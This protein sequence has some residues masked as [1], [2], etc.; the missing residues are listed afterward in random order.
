MIKAL[1]KK[2]KGFTLIETVVSVAIFALISF[3]LLNLFNAVFRNIKN[4]KA[5]LVANTIAVER[6][7][8]IRGM[9]FNQVKTTTGWVGGQIPSETNIVRDGINFLVRTDITWVDDPYDGV[10][11]GTVNDSFPFDYKKVRVRI[12]WTNPIGGGSQE[13]AT[14]TDVAPM[15]LEGLS[16]GKGGIYVT[17]YNSEGIVVSEADVEVNSN[18]ESYS[19]SGVKTDLNG[20]LWIPDLSPSDDYHIKVTKSG[21][22]VAETYAVNNDPSSE[23]YNP[24]PNPANALVIEQKITKIGFQIDATGMINI[25]TVHFDNPANW[26]VNVSGAGEQTESAMAISAS[27]DVFVAWADDRDAEKHIYMQK[28][29]YNSGTGSYDASWSSDARVVN[30]PDSSYPK[31]KIVPDGSLYLAW[32]DNR[33]SNSNIY[34]QEINTANGNLIGSEYQIGHDSS[35]SAQQN[36]D[37]TND[38]DGNLYIVWEDYRNATW[39]IYMQKFIPSSGTFWTDDLKINNSG[40]NEQINAKVVSDRNTDISGGNQNNIYVAWQSNHSGNFDILFSKFNKDGAV[41]FS[42]YV[43]NSD[44]GSLNQYNPS[45]IFDGSASIYVAWADERDAQPD[46][47]LQ[48][49]DGSGNKAFAADV[50]IN[51]DSFATAQRDKPSI[52]FCSDSAIYVSWEDNRNGSA[53][54]NIYSSK[55]DSAAARQWTYDLLLA[56]TMNGNQE[57]SSTACD[58]SGNAVAVWQDNRGAGDNNIYGTSY[59]H[60][61]NAIRTGVPITIKSTKNKGS[62]LNVSGETVYI[63]KYEETFMSDGGGNISVNNMEWGS[64]DFSTTG[65]YSIISFDLPSPISVYPGNTTNIIINVGP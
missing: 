48:K 54:Y 34:L 58:L 20:N 59:N 56:D 64:Y 65:A 15:G 46:I 63:P 10:D 35:G 51:D 57:N 1:N 19:L 13:I 42:E 26:Q 7:E 18:A 33:D 21:Y 45:M 30:Q 9:N 8:V 40:S 28:L 37:M 12:S 60:M 31:L 24:V 22:S 23:D 47:Y 29:I 61:G 4:N 17:A 52:G 36:I 55:I 62:Y 50:K 11:G 2:V 5:I 49:M 44:G 53:Y 16:D 25:R 43:V 14:N 27:G 3:T 39:D 41:S 38:Q 6:L 32:N